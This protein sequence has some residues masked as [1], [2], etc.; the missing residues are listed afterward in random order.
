MYTKKRGPIII[1][2]N[3]SFRQETVNYPNYCYA[4]DLSNNTEINDNGVQELLLDFQN[5]TGNQ[6]EINMQGITLS[7]RRDVTNHAFSDAGYPIR[8]HNN[9]FVRKYSVK[10]KK[11]TIVEEDPNNKCRVYPNNDFVNYR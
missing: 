8:L 11:S 9:G 10:I 5:M 7:C 6:L 1:Q 4:L 3:E 2:L